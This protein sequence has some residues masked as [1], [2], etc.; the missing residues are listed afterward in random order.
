MQAYVKKFLDYV[1]DGNIDQVLMEHRIHN[2]DIGSLLDE[3]NFK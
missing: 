2:Y 3:A 1:K